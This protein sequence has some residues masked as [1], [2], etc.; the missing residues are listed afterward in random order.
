[1]QFWLR[2][3]DEIVRYNPHTLSKKEEELLSLISPALE[4]NSNTYLLLTDA[5]MKYGSVLND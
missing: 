5:D 3:F 2:R 4:S 1:M